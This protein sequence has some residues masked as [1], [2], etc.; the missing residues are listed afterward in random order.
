MGG[1]AVVAC[2]AISPENSMAARVA[3]LLGKRQ[4]TLSSGTHA[5]FS[6]AFA[7]CHQP[8]ICSRVGAD[9]VS[10]FS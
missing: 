5:L 7:A 3:V 1:I 4:S 8:S 6:A 2:S 9:P 10:D